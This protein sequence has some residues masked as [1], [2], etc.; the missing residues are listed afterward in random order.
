MIFFLSWV[1]YR[2]FCFFSHIFSV[3]TI[4]ST[5]SYFSYPLFSVPGVGLYLYAFLHKIILTFYTTGVNQLLQQFCKLFL[6]RWIS[7]YLTKTRSH[8]S[9][10][11]FHLIVLNLTTVHQPDF[12]VAADEWIVCSRDEREC[13][14][15]SHSLPFPMVHSHSQSQV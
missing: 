6:N 9:S 10:Y 12:F 11:F 15:Q 5:F 1:H 8:S 14:F 2:W 13:L 4:F 7:Y 3:F